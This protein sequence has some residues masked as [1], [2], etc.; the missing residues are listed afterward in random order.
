M[1][2]SKKTKVF[3]A[4][5]IAIVVLLASAS[6]CAQ[7]K[8]GWVRQFDSVTVEKVAPG[9]LPST[10]RPGADT[11]IRTESDELPKPATRE[12]LRKIVEHL[13]ARVVQ[14]VA[15]QTP[16]KPYRQ[17]PMVHHGHAVWI[18]PPG[19]GNPVLVS[20]LSWL[21][22][23]DEVF[24]T[25]D[26]LADDANAQASWKSRRRSLAAVTAGSKGE[27]WLE[28]HKEELIAVKPHRPDRHRN[29]VTLVAADGKLKAPSSGVELFDVE[30]KALF[31]LYG[32][33]P[34]L[35]KSLTQTK[36][37]PAHPDEVALAFYW[38]TTYPAILGAPLVSENGK[39]VSIN[40]FRHPKED[41]EGI[42]L[43]IPT[44][45]IASYLAPDDGE[46]EE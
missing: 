45:A 24:V 41:R 7:Q 22:D 20:P 16:P 28:E 13:E 42:Y 2:F 33:S 25:P 8:K 5:A 34:Y 10:T 3:V 44:G 4:P 15:V 43:A 29:L 23:A 31:R 12:Q 40:T 35:G 26:D 1:T 39:L 19:D 9:D 11:A 37:L 38:Q 6:V 18:T 32:Y 27:E 21:K 46:K 30:N 36:M 17:V 14:V